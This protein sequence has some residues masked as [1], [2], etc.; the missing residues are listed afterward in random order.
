MVITIALQLFL[1]TSKYSLSLVLVIWNSV[2]CFTLAKLTC[3]CITHWTSWHKLVFGLRS[4]PNPN[5]CVLRLN[6]FLTFVRQSS[7]RLSLLS[8]TYKRLAYQKSDFNLMKLSKSLFCSTPTP[9][10]FS[11]WTKNNSLHLSYYRQ[12]GCLSHQHTTFQHVLS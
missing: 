9:I 12:L 4:S 6:L 1:G 11:V 3:S 7:Q 10:L 2:Q 8:N 5:T